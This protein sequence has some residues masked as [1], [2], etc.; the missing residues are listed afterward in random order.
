MPSAYL[1]ASAAL[2][3]FYG[4]ISDL[5]GR[6]AVLYPVIVLFLV[7][8]HARQ[9]LRVAV[10]TSEFPNLQVGSAL[11]GAAQS[12]TWLILARALQGVGGGGIFQMVN[13]VI[14]DIVPLHKWVL[15]GFRDFRI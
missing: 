12:M 4:K 10:L 11:C 7:R 14:G 8:G 15:C 5:V 6:K 13:I 2:S 9:Q 1:L 3:S